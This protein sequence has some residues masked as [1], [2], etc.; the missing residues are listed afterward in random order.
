MARG[1]FE[2]CSRAERHDAKKQRAAHRSLRGQ[3]QLA[4]S[5]RRALFMERRCYRRGPVGQ[6][7]ERFGV[8]GVEVQRG[9][10]NGSGK[11]RRVIRIRLNVPIDSLL[12]QPE[13]TAPARIF[14]FTEL[15][16]RDLL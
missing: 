12:K 7:I 14:S 8:R 16:A 2:R 3:S 10:G 11:N 1:T 4:F 13:I 5:I 9:D 15:V 6:V